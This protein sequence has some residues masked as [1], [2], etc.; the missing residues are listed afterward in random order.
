MNGND[1]SRIAWNAVTNPTKG[2]SWS[3]KSGQNWQNPQ[4]ETV[5]FKTTMDAAGSLSVRSALKRQN[6]TN[7]PFF[8]KRLI[9]RGSAGISI[10]IPVNAGLGSPNR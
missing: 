9:L 4:K 7:N 8:M 1:T 3:S 10:D 2:P 6:L 5:V